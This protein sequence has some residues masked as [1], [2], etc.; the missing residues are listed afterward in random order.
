LL[1]VTILSLA[2]AACSSGPIGS[3]IGAGEPITVALPGNTGTLALSN[4][5]PAATIVAS[6]PGYGGAFSAS[7][8]NTAIATVA[9]SGAA[10]TFTVSAVSGGTTT[11]SISDSYGSKVTVPVGVT[12]NVGVISDR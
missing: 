8:A 12:W 11:V 7:S 1:F 6:E 4:T 5:M 3:F 2:T 9:P 10:G